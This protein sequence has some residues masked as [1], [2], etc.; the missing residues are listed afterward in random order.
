MLVVEDGLVCGVCVS[1][2]RG[3]FDRVDAGGRKGKEIKH[4][5]EGKRHEKNK[6]GRE[7]ERMRER[8]RYRK[9]ETNI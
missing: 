7:G 1:V 2:W 9:E 3:R 5:E 4:D 8:G 6:R